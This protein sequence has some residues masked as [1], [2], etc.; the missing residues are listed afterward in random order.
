MG[1]LLHNEMVLYGFQFIVQEK[2]IIKEKQKKMLH[3]CYM[4]R[5]F[6]DNN[7]PWIMSLIRELE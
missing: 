3:S 1:Y 5:F 7:F 6:S 4:Q 2:I